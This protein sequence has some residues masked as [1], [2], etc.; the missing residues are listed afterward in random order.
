MRFNREVEVVM[1]MKKNCGVRQ[2]FEGEMSTGRKREKRK[3][4]EVR[5]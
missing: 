5:V 1:E 2:S 3:L 4:V